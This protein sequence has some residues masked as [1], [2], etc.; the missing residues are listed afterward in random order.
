MNVAEL[1]FGTIFTAWA[2]TL[3]PPTKQPAE[4]RAVGQAVIFGPA[5]AQ[6]PP[7]LLIS[8]STMAPVTVS[9]NEFI[10]LSAEQAR[11]SHYAR[12]SSTGQLQHPALQWAWSTGQEERPSPEAG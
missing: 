7:S 6:W 11:R 5:T 8:P 10:N 12:I 1:R 2:S 3:L 4:A 9:N